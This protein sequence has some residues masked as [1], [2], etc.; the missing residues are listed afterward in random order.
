[1]SQVVHGY[2]VRGPTDPY[3]PLISEEPLWW[4]DGGVDLCGLRGCLIRPDS[5]A[6][7]V[8]GKSEQT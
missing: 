5:V 6:P 3:T 4:C 8:D 1:M 7:V 2:S